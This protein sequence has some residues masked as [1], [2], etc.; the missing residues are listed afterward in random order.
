MLRGLAQ[1]GTRLLELLGGSLGKIDKQPAPP[2]VFADAAAIFEPLHAYFVA[3]LT[4]GGECLFESFDGVQP[5][6][7]CQGLRDENP[8]KTCAERIVR[9]CAIV[10]Y[11][12]STI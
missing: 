11:R 1:Y 8:G 10:A 3:K 2:F 6:A 4:D 12:A 5:S 7:S 9:L